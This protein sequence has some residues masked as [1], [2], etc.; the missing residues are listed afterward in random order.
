MEVESD[1]TKVFSSFDET[2]AKMACSVSALD[3]AANILVSGFVVDDLF[4]NSIS[5]EVKEA[6]EAD[7]E[8]EEEEEKYQLL[9]FGLLKDVMSRERATS[10]YFLSKLQQRFMCA[11]ALVRKMCQPGRSLR[12]PSKT[13]YDSDQISPAQSPSQP[14]SHRWAVPATVT[15]NGRAVAGRVSRLRRRRRRRPVQLQQQARHRSTRARPERREQTH[16]PVNESETFE[17]RP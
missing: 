13:H 14:A 8:E 12:T 2:N 6:K 9:L 5:R 7:M 4:Y 10:S 3:A 17:K 11:S 16:D 1:F 15:A